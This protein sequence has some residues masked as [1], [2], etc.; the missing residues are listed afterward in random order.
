MVSLVFKLF[1]YTLL[2]EGKYKRLHHS[3]DTGF[4]RITVKIKI[5]IVQ[6][7]RLLSIIKIDIKY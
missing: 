7:I 4:Y 1:G 2:Q 5:G 6:H 3:I